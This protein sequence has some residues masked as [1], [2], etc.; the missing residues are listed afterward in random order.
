MA[1]RR[2]GDKPLPEPMVVS[3]PTY[4]CVTR[5]QWVN[6]Q[7]L[8]ILFHRFSIVMLFVGFIFS[9][10]LKQLRPCVTIIMLFLGICW[11]SARLWVSSVYY[12]WSYVFL[13]PTHRYGTSIP[14]SVC[15]YCQTISKHCDNR[16]NG[17]G[18]A[19]EIV[20]EGNGFSIRFG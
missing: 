8:K 2:P 18:N 4:I 7:T 13:A 12:Q 10:V 1:W 17:C 20:I 6:T 3:W 15:I 16:S 5:P 9:W 19:A 14:S 11:L